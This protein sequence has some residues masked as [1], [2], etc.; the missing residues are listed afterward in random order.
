MAPASFISISRRQVFVP[1]TSLNY[2]RK[3][4]R[5]KHAF[6]EFKPIEL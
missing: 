6:E 1:S 5:H 2:K 3:K 4:W